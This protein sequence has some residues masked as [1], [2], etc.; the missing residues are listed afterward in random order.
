MSSYPDSSFG[1]E[2]QLT[3][4]FHGV[5]PHM[6]MEN[7]SWT[8]WDVVQIALVALLS[9][10]V[11]MTFTVFVA[12]WLLF[13]RLSLMVVARMP[14]VSVVAQFLGYVVTFAFMVAVV[15][16][17]ANASFWRE[18]SW[19]WP[20]NSAVYLLAGVVLSLVL[21]GVAHF[22]P[23]PKQL[24][25]DLFFQTSTEAWVLSIFGVT[26][27]PFMEEMFF[28]GFLYPVL[29]RR[30]GMTIAILLTATAFGL[31]HA[32][33]L[34][35][36]WA[37]ILVVFLVGLVLTLTRA[38][39]RSVARGMLIHIGYNGMLSLLLFVASDGFRHLEKLNQ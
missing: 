33:Q 25:I 36:A 8:G 6:L 26:V 28:R 24:P 5:P 30:V 13:P 18:I 20:K 23:M 31:L 39:T 34:G 38:L 1:P 7:P 29:A 37:P 27:A 16:R 11:L 35:R 4:E 14:L 19:N 17:R 2:P 9:I 3:P 22:L 32:P 21:Q 12:Q 10:S 15:R